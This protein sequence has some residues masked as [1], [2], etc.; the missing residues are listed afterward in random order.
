MHNNHVIDICQITPYGLQESLL[1]SKFDENRPSMAGGK[2]TF[3]KLQDHIEMVLPTHGCTLQTFLQEMYLLSKFDRYSQYVVGNN[4][5]FSEP[6][7]Y[8]VMVSPTTE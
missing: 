5:V 4:E 7:D 8:V 2:Q 6:G 1:L 3:S